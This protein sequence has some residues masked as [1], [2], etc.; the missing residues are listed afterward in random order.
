MK[1]YNNFRDLIIKVE[2]EFVDEFTLIV[3]IQ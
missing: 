2:I 3:I 1:R